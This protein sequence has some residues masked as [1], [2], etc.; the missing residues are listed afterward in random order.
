MSVLPP[1]DPQPGLIDDAALFRQ[2]IGI[3]ALLAAWGRVW[4]NGGAAG[5]DGVGLARFQ[6]DVHR[7]LARLHAALTDGSYRPG[8]L[9]RVD[10]PKPDGGV[11]P[12]AIPCIVDRVAQT[13]VAQ[14]L[15][16]LLDAA[17][18]PASFGYRSGRGVKDALRRVAELRARGHVYVVDADI[19]RYFDRVPHEPLLAQLGQLMQDGPLTRLIAL[20]LEHAGQGGRGLAQGSP[21]SPLLANL[22]LDQLD[23]A[24]G[25]R[26]AHIV[27]FADDFVI[28]AESRAGAEGAL[29]KAEALLREAG[30]A[31][32]RAKTRITSFDQGFRFL[33]ALFVRSMMLPGAEAD[34]QDATLQ[35]MRAL[36]HTDAQTDAEAEAEDERFGQQRRQGYDPGHRV[37]YVVSPD[38]RLA[39]RNQAYAVQAGT[40]T[41]GMPDAGLCYEWHELLA[42]PPGQVD[43]IDLGP[44]ASYQPQALAQALANG[45]LV[46]FVDGHGQTQGWL[47]PALT[48]RAG[49]HLAQAEHALHEARRLRLARAFVEGRVRNQRALL[50]RLNRE[51]QAPGVL[52]ALS[53]LNTVLR[54]LPNTTALAELM[55]YEGQAAA[56]YWPALGLC[57]ERGFT[58]HRR[59]REG[60]LDATNLLLNVTAALLARDVAVAVG[61]AGLH[62]GFGYLHSIDNGRDALV[63]DLME[64]FRAPLAESAMVRAINGRAV[65]HDDFEPRPDGGLRLLPHAYAAMVRCYEQAVGREVK[66]QRDGKRRPWRAIMLDQALRLAAHVEGRGTYQAYTIDY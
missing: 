20:W 7:R 35:A 24:F 64:E 40:S 46:A 9:R 42:I 56:A 47:S 36:A 31:L 15:S 23:D 21:L 12:L 39:L 25:R 45:T 61:R 8:P 10:I 19:E 27:R 14:A 30:L 4:S 6:H 28:L 18:S 44:Q 34:A 38:R 16:P 1:D 66:S 32:N 50:R 48:D 54:A 52:P 53:T 33:G 41:P 11:R 29:A 49:R 26:G 55:G 43:R 57:L 37:L 63:F 22:Y 59:V 5:G 62:A 60:R 51:R 13:A 3:E 17:F 2:A 65:S 58:L